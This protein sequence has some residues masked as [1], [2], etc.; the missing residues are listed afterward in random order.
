MSGRAEERKSDRAE[1]RNTG[2]P[3]KLESRNKRGTTFAVT[4][5]TTSPTL[6]WES[7]TFLAT[8]ENSDVMVVAIVITR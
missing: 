2:T 8:V 3:E 1:E 4:V 5:V 7:G 6:K